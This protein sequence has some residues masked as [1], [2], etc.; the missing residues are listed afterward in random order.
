MKTAGNFAE[1]LVIALWHVSTLRGVDLKRRIFT[2][3]IFDPHQFKKNLFS[4]DKSHIFIVPVIF[5]IITIIMHPWCETACEMHVEMVNCFSTYIKEYHKRVVSKCKYQNFWATGMSFGRTQYSTWLILVTS[6]Y[7][8]MTSEVEVTAGN[9]LWSNNSIQV[10][11]Q[12]LLRSFPHALNILIEIIGPLCE[13]TVLIYRDK[14]ARCWP[15]RTLTWIVSPCTFERCLHRS[16]ST[17]GFLWNILPTYF[18]IIRKW[19]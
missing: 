4:P 1:L 8:D 12:S 15:C 16:P 2:D 11:L 6:T 10:V 13:E 18:S 5:T 17:L 9:N 3:L 14:P 7:S 19:H